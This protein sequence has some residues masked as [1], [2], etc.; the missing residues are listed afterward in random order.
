M[1]YYQSC[2]W[3]LQDF[4]YGTMEENM[5]GRGASSGINRVG[6]NKHK[7]SIRSNRKRIREHQEKINKLNKSRNQWK[8]KEIRNNQGLIKHWQAEIRA[9]RKNIRD[10]VQAIRGYKSK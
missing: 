9:F 1:Q 4:S 3:M 8:G 7:K 6:A 5:G 10:S 2:Y